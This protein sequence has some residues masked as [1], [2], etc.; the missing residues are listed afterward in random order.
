MNLKMKLSILDNL[1]WVIL[2]AL[3]VINIFI[4]PM[5]FSYNN[6]MNI[7]YHS[8]VLGF[9]VLGESL[10]LIT[11][12]FD[13]SIESTLA[14]APAIGILFMTRWMPGLNPIIGIIITLG[15]GMLIGYFNGLFIGRLKINPFLQ[16]LSI[17]II[18]RGLTYYLIPMSIFNLPRVYTFLGGERIIFKIPIAVIVLIV[19]IYII[20]VILTKGVYGRSLIA[21]GGNIRASFISGI[22]TE[23]VIILAYTFSGLFAAIAGILSVGRQE[24]ITNAMGTGMVFMAFAAAVMGGVSMSGGIGT[25]L[26]MLGGLL[27][28]GV[29]DNAL[30]LLGVNVFL[31]YAT[32]GILIFIAILLDHS[33]ISIREKLIYKEE[34]KKFKV[35]TKK[36]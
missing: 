25:A 9:L 36:A 30:T 10:C 11:G 19:F 6:L 34:V 7:I 23:R 28:L 2:F 18:L 33:K 17:L 4:T 3:V 5:F 27:V 22:N 12:N 24:A 32:K 15:V 1:I 8:A 14:F 13:L 31:V 26:G 35:K 20:H 29:I 21:V 16:T